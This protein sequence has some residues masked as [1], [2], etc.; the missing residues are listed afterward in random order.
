[1]FG[2]WHGHAWGQ[3]LSLFEPDVAAVQEKHGDGAL[4]VCRKTRCYPTQRWKNVSHKERD[5]WGRY[6]QETG[7]KAGKQNKNA[8]H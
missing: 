7:V 3:A 6:S 4:M 1:M 5:G 8:G 2:V